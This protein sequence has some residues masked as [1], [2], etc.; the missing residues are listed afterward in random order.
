MTL[1]VLFCRMSEKWDT[2]FTLYAK[3]R[4]DAERK[5]EELLRKYPFERLD[6]KAYPHGFRFAMTDL[7]GRIE[8]DRM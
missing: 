4:E 7:P 3:D 2:L 1:W 8:E 5:A 6:L